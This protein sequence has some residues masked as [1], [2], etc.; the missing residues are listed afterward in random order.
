MS[1]AA[2]ETIVASLISA[3]ALIAV[4]F[5]TT[6]GARQSLQGRRAAEKAAK[7]SASPNGKTTGKKVDWLERSMLAVL[8]HLGLEVPPEDPPGHRHEHD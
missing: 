7:E 2:G 8:E 3:I 4:A 6:Y 1:L 5:I